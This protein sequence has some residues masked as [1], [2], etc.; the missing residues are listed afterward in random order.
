MGTMRTSASTSTVPLEDTKFEER[1][2][3]R[4]GGKQAS[5]INASFSLSDLDSRTLLYYLSLTPSRSSVSLFIA[6][7]LAFDKANLFYVEQIDNPSQLNWAVQ[8]KKNS[9]TVK[10]YLPCGIRANPDE[11]MD[12][13]LKFDQHHELIRYVGV[14]YKYAGILEPVTQKNLVP[15]Y[16][17]GPKEDAD[18]SVWSPELLKMHLESLKTRPEFKEDTKHKLRVEE[19]ALQYMLDLVLARHEEKQILAVAA[20]SKKRSKPPVVVPWVD[21]PRGG[22][23]NPIIT[24]APFAAALE[25]RPKQK[26]RAGDV[27]KYFHPVMTRD[28]CQGVIVMV[29]PPRSKEGKIAIEMQDSALLPPTCHVKLVYRRLN[30]KMVEPRDKRN[31]Y[32]EISAFRLDPSQNGKVQIVNKSDQ[33]GRAYRETQNDLRACGSDFWRGNA[34]RKQKDANGHV[35]DDETV[36]QYEPSTLEGSMKGRAKVPGSAVL[37]SEEVCWETPPS[38]PGINILSPGTDDAAATSDSVAATGSAINSFK[39]KFDRI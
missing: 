39:R 10:A 7:R 23:P 6:K 18:L 32:E 20:A 4:N 35:K 27:I 30:R 34:K 16:G 2:K 22:S 38:G 26:L 24:H 15:Y 36:E 5:R 14:H 12:I 37:A 11:R 9:Q 17:S 1:G 33:L 19:L 28:E 3:K 29:N 8:K 13:G 31:F 21:P 25:D